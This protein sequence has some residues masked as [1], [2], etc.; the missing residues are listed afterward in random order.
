MA[1]PGAMYEFVRPDTVLVVVGNVP[2]GV[3]GDDRFS[4]GVTCGVPLDRQRYIVPHGKEHWEHLEFDWDS[5]V[6]CVFAWVGAL[7]HPVGKPLL[8]GASMAHTSDILVRLNES[9]TVLDCGRPGL[10]CPIVPH[11][12]MRSMW[13][14]S[15]FDSDLPDFLDTGDPDFC[16]GMPLS[17]D[18]VGTVESDCDTALLARGCFPGL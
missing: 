4:P 5:S 7:D 18:G 6:A 16:F 13:R 12:R 11:N 15:V 3:F 8:D 17:R 2:T 1:E 9:D 14:L 10:Y